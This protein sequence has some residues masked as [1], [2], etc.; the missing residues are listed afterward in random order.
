MSDTSNQAD[1]YT[2]GR[3]P[4]TGFLVLSAAG[5][6]G[7]AIIG[8]LGAL[9]LSLPS[10][11]SG[12][13][14]FEVLRPTHTF[15]A[16][17]AVLSGLFGL[18]ETILVRRGAGAG[19]PSLVFGFAAFMLAGLV[20]IAS[21][22]ATGREYFP[23]PVW[24]S[25]ILLPIMFSYV[26]RLFA[27]RQALIERSP[28]G[29][30]LLGFG[31]LF[32]TLAWLETHLR[33]LDSM[34]GSFT[35]DLSVQWHAID[36]MFAGMNTVLF[37]AVMF[38]MNVRPRPLRPWV[39]FGIS[40]FGVV[41]TFGH[42]HYASPQPGVIKILAVIASMV[43]I[44]SLFRHFIAWRKA[45][46]AATDPDFLLPVLRSVEFWVIVSVAS[47]IIFAI[48]QINLI[49]HGTYLTLI[50]AMGSMI[51]VNFMI[52]VLGA[53]AFGSNVA[54]VRADRIKWG[55]RL[56]NW[57]IGGLWL[58]LGAA[59]AVRGWMRI[60]HEYAEFQPIREVILVGFPLVGVILLAGILI[61]SREI[62]RAQTVPDGEPAS[63]ALAEQGDAALRR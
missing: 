62:I 7:T 49:T 9:K 6:V 54:A 57:S 59:G 30:W 8:L 16:M 50:H 38:M 10:E 43:A 47:G 26:W 11:M 40:A 52:I 58:V 24:A 3:S 48:P 36:T 25:V 37:G 4:A 13:L 29:F 45:Q 35:R 22:Q 5:F 34:L 17:S 56:T 12:W 51:G 1:K 61:L 32:I 2:S 28:E 46:G 20:A 19:H 60:G 42:H 33:L 23:A 18:V 55:V 15:L 14:A 39:L 63:L 31:S 21:G 44:L 27:A 41:L 53:L